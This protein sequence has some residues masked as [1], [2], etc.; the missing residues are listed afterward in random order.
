MWTVIGS[1]YIGITSSILIYFLFES[2]FE[3]LNLEEAISYSLFW[4]LHV[5]KI[6]VRA[7]LFI[8]KN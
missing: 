1:I 5:L 3:G 7:F 8:F 4:P 2:L 6:L